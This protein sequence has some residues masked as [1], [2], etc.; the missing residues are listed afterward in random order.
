MKMRVAFVIVSFILSLSIGLVLALG[1]RG[2]FKEKQIKQDILIGLSMDTLKEARWQNDKKFFLE[3]A[4]EL[5]AR[6]LVQ[7]ANSDDARQLQDVSA[8]ISSG[9]DVLVIVPHNGK[10][11]AKAVRMASDAG[12]PVIAYDRLIMDSSP[13]LYI[14]F[15]GYKVG[16][17]Q[18]EYLIEK[19]LPIKNKIRIIR[20]YGS[21]MDNNAFLFKEGQDSVLA[22]Y[23]KTGQV[24]VIHE[25]WAEDWK[26]EDAK[27]IV[28]AAITKYGYEFDAVLASNDGTAG[29]AIQ[30]L[31]EEGIAGKILVT[32][33]DAELVACKRIITGV[34]TMTVYKP[35][36]LLAGQA[37][38]LAVNLAR[39]KPIVAK[40]SVN[41][42][43]IDV[44]AVFISVQAVDKNNIKETVIADGFYTYNQSCPVN[45]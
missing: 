30:T 5:G 15:D 8:L 1:N 20:I 35:I 13:E 32:G 36:K 4:E 42:G 34:Q 31:I 7:A 11:M 2:H 9:V 18:A 14:T 29:G 17:I 16:Q 6:V 12:I 43:K 24:E 39:G 41:N 19:L 22:S 26:P 45:V 37:V 3:K 23:I 10:A 25:D 38:E 28:N 40:S 21:K 33:Q 27:R 44:P